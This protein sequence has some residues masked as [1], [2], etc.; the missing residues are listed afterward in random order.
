MKIRY[1]IATDKKIDVLKYSLTVFV[2]SV[3]SAAFIAVALLSLSS[4][5]NRFQIEKAQLRKY[6]NQIEMKRKNE[7]VFA[8]DIAK[9]KASWNK[10]IAFA[11]SIIALKY[12]PFLERL[13]FLE[14]RLPG[15]V[16]ITKVILKSDT[17]GSIQF[18]IASIS[19]EK[20][21]EIFK[22]FSKYSLS[23]N[24]AP[25]VEGLFKANLEIKLPNEKK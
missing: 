22:A 11:N 16:F 6:K 10:R 1:N 18:G 13:N 5:L 23:I 21:M 2:L 20:L 7:V 25:F 8:A 14:E 19:N 3:I 17:S 24:E 4:T 12:F 9:T 15:G